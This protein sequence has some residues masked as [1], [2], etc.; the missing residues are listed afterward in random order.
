MKSARAIRYSLARENERKAA[1][2][3]RAGSQ[4]HAAKLHGRRRL[5]RRKQRM[6]ED[7]VEISDPGIACGSLERMTYPS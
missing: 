2:Q 1:V 4:G 6:S 5:Q 7:L 3:A